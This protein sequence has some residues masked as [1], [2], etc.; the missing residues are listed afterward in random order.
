MKWARTEDQATWGELFRLCDE[1]VG[2]EENEVLLFCFEDSTERR[3]VIHYRAVVDGVCYG[4]ECLA[5]SNTDA[6]FLRQF[7]SRAHR[8]RRI[9]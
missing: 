6:K 4:I 3:I 1:A 8:Q 7:L 9:A 5:L 2:E